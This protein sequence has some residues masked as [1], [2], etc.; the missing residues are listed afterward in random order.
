[1][2]NLKISFLVSCFESFFSV[3]LIGWSINA[4]FSLCCFASNAA[5]FIS[6]PGETPTSLPSFDSM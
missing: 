2:K 5:A 6:S 1:M 3:I 4:S